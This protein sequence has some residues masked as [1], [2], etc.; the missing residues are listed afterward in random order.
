[1]DEN[2]MKAYEPAVVSLLKLIGEDPAREGLAKTPHRVV[3][4]LLELTSG[5]HQ[6]PKK[7]LA[8]TFTEACNEMVIVRDIRFWSL[9]EHHMLPFHGSATVGYL[10]K[11]KIV[12]LS[13][14][15]RLVH[16]YARR[17][18]VQE[19]MT[20]QIANSLME[21]LKPHGVGVVIKATH[22]CM[23]MRGAK[24]PAEMMTSCL[25]GDF[26]EPATRAEFLNLR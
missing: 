22:L 3:K 19:R 14:I 2:E 25:L 1:M 23:E 16:C 13:K 17:L 21:H 6:D 7:I 11:D 15:G 5:Y 10:P 12:G 18:Q 24:T 20:E 8:T 26:R 9:C 4:S